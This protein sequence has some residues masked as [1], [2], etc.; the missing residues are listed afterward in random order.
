MMP[1]SDRA[2]GVA[3]FWGVSVAIVGGKR[4][5]VLLAWGRLPIFHADRGG[6]TMEGR[7]LPEGMSP[8]EFACR[9]NL[10]KAILPHRTLARY[11]PAKARPRS[12]NRRADALRR[13]RCAMTRPFWAS[14]P[15]G[16]WCFTPLMTREALYVYIAFPRNHLQK[17]THHSRLTPFVVPA[18]GVAA[19]LSIADAPV[20]KLIQGHC[21]DNNRSDGDLLVPL[22][23][24]DLTAAHVKNRDHQCAD[25]RT[26][27]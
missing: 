19:N 24:P 11:D 3:R 20:S 14:L 9:S 23:E 5:L 13:P 7:T 27:D 12:T 18:D 2:V 17:F 8:E 21:A 16:S 1:K 4:G 15:L 10:A 22:L 25:Q 26:E 6:W